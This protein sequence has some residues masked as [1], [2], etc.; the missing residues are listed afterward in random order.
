MISQE[1]DEIDR[2]E[3]IITG[4]EEEIVKKQGIL[5]RIGENNDW[6]N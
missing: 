1:N 6:K 2:W 5:W 3:G 4:T